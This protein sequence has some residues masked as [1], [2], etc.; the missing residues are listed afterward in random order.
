MKNNA[1]NKRRSL[2]LPAVLSFLALVL[3]VAVFGVVRYFCLAQGGGFQR[4]VLMR[5]LWETVPALCALAAFGLFMLVL[6]AVCVAKPLKKMR[7]SA[8]KIAERVEKHAPVEAIRGA[9][10]V[11]ALSETLA[12]EEGK[13]AELV[14]AVSEEA[15]ARA[16]EREKRSAA[17]NICAAAAPER[18]EFGALT[19]GVRACTLRAPSVGADFCDGFA[20]DG[21]RVFIAVGD[22]WEQ[23]LSAA[24]ACAR[25]TRKLREQIAAG[26]SPAVAL[27]A[28]NAAALENGDTAT[29]F[30]A[31][32][33]SVSGELRYANAGHLPPVIAGETSGFLRMRAGVPVGLYADA[34]FADETFSLRPGQ[35][36]IVYTDGVVNAFDGKEYFGYGRLLVTVNKYYGNALTADGVAEGVVGAVEEFGAREDD[37]AVLAL[38]F[39]AG[40]QRLLAPELPELEKMRELLDHWLQEDPRKK[41][42]Q[43]ACEEIFTNIVGHAGAKAIQISCEREENSLIIRFTDDGEPF[44]PLQVESGGREFEAYAEGGMGMTIIRR[45]AGE[46]FYRTQQNLNVLTIRF[47]VIKG[48]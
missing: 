26:K 24:L 44:N 25:L 46:I 37:C 30:C 5:V 16:E 9:G 3:A 14:N 13:L 40:V 36:L 20:L 42:I 34:E 33:D 39:P 6:L 29:L 21:R 45:I 7:G 11:G 27:S 38:S 8:S 4:N 41:N 43:L 19:Y 22:V 17:L 28:V 48:I 2:F 32:F 47:P 18:L 12:K 15:D 1:K 23:G 10:C 31:V 35:G